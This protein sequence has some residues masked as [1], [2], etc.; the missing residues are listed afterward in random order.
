MRPSQ[1]AAGDAVEDAQ[2]VVG[3]VAMRMRSRMVGRCREGGDG[4]PGLEA[5][6]SWMV[7]VAITVTGRPLC[8]PSAGSPRGGAEDR[9]QGVVLALGVAASIPPA[10]QEASPVVRGDTWAAHA[11]CGVLA[12]SASIMALF[13]VAISAV[14]SCC[15]DADH[16]SR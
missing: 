15:Q 7:A 16:G 11:G 9:G 10:A 4:V 6:R 12:S 2:V 3:G 5:C 14:C 13:G 1:G 8:W